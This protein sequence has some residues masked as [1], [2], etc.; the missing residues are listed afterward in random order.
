MNRLLLAILTLT[1]IACGP[2]NHTDSD[3]GEL[4]ANPGETTEEPKPEPEP[5]PQY[6]DGYNKIIAALK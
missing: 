3:W 2:E 4:P 1:F 5:K 6:H